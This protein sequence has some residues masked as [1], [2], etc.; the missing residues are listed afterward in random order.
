MSTFLPDPG[1]AGPWQSARVTPRELEVFWLVGD[2]LPNRE[3]AERLRLSE[4]TVE[5]HVSALLR[6]LGGANRLALVEAAERLRAHREL[7]GVLPKPLSSFV[8]RGRE[9]ADVGELVSA[10]RLVTL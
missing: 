1:P 5:S 8:G 10:H 2:R 9:A 7:G 3:I 4:R 6:K